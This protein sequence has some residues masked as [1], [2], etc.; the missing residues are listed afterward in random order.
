M[1]D[2]IARDPAA[3]RQLASRART[4]V[5]AARPR[6]PVPDEQRQKIASAFF[7]ASRSGNLGQLKQLLA[8][9]VV[10]YADG[11]GKRNSSIKPIHGLDKVSR[12]LAALA[13]KGWSAAEVVRDAS[14]DG[15]PG[16]ITLENDALPQTI[17]VDID[18]GKIKAI[19]VTRNPDKLARLGPLSGA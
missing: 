7:A 1:A 14:I 12:F 10:F 17:A 3:A 18:D 8:D 15:L 9:D 19:Y 2:A 6:F 5:A 11:G 4:P 13:G 16:Q